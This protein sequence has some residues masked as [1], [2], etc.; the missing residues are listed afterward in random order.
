MEL[1][2]NKWKNT[3]EFGELQSGEAFYFPGEDWYGMKLYSNSHDGDNAVDIATGELA[4]LLADDTVIP[5][6]A[7]III[8]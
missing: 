8:E 5:V 7:K 3:K 1:V 2:I 6:K 4:Q